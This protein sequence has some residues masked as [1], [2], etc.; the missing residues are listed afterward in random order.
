MLTTSPPPTITNEQIN[1]LPLLLGICESMGIRATLDALIQP[2]GAWQGASV[3]TLVTVWLAH[4]LQE[5]THCLVQVRDWVAARTQ[6][7]ATLLGCSLRETDF[8]DD[9]LANVLTM[10]GTPARQ[11]ALTQALVQQWVRVYHLPVQTA[12]LDSTTVSVYHDPT[13]PDSL[14]QLGH[15]KDHRP[16]LRQFKAM[17]STLDPLGLPVCCQPVAGQ[18]ADDGLYVPAYE[19]TVATLG[20]RDL[21]VV[22]DSK[23]GAAATRGHVAAR[24]SRYLCAY[25]P[26][27][28]GAELAAWVERALLRE[29]QGCVLETADPRT[30]ELRPAGVVVG[31]ER[32]QSWRD[33]VT[34]TLHSWTERVLLY[35]STA[36]QRGLTDLHARQVAR[37]STEI[38]A[39]AAP[40]GR[41]RKRYRSR[42]EIEAAVATILTR[43]NVAEVLEVT[44]GEDP[45]ED[46][47]GAR[48]WVPRGIACRC[49][50]W[51]GYV[52]RQGWQVYLTNAPEDVYSAA[53]IVSAYHGQPVHERG[54]ARL[55]SR[56]LQIRPIYVRDEQRITGLLWLL[57]L[58]LQVLTLTEYRVRGALAA[59]Q[60]EVAG[61]NPASRT[62]TTARPTTERL[63]AAFQNLTVTVW[64]GGGEIH[65]YVTPL[66]ATQ[67]H[68]L[69]LLDLPA[70]LYSRLACPLLNSS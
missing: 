20:T 26:P 66:N 18:V 32:P 30:G 17:L 25:R 10:L 22:G 15:S 21:L 13:A 28:A 6:T 67:V 70:D 42:A 3:G 57:V 68:I 46:P 1:S 49:P 35:R 4:I 9:R 48:R 40:A 58:A 60:E 61:L 59:A 52:A 37:A 56:T 39:L 12:R 54:F 41:G 7:I 16:D 27:A 45:T 5:R 63:I 50:A 24:G 11:T 51:A 69:R 31:W 33:P 64:A 29:E 34:G 55:K 36:Y 47:A 2:H 44:V 19:N 62:Q 43:R 23:M 65:R 53:Q 8:T 38:A 14:L